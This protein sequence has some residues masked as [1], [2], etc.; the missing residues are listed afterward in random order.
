M[1]SMTNPRTAAAPTRRVSPTVAAR[2]IAAAVLHGCGTSSAKA[3]TTA[4]GSMARP[5]HPVGEAARRILRDALRH[6]VRAHHDAEHGIGAAPRS[7]EQGQ[8]GQ[9]GA[10]AGSD[11]KDRR[12]DAPERGA[13]RP[14][15]RAG[16]HWPRSQQ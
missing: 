11:E 7:K 2:A 6:E 9:H 14:P 10:D 1:D 13:P 12:N 8:D 4:A 3:T 15:S 5:A 16:R